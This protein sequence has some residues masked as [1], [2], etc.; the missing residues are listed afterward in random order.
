MNSLFP[1][2]FDAEEIAAQLHVCGLSQVLFNIH[3]GDWEVGERGWR[4]YLREAEFATSV[5]LAVWYA[6]ALGCKRLHVM[7]GCADADDPRCKD[8][9]LS[10]IDFAA[11]VLDAGITTLIE[12]INP[13]DMP[14][15]YLTD[16]D[17]ALEN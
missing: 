1:Y 15:Y 16:L 12:P 6:E 11:A 17:Q 9:F 10:N 5:D 14:N 7:A 4:Y 13:I 3:P 8:V 2:E